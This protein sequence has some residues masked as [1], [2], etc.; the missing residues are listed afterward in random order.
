MCFITGSYNKKYIVNIFFIYYFSLLII[1][2][3]ICLLLLIIDY[4]KSTKILKFVCYLIKS[5]FNFM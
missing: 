5:L 1:V 4:L 2:V 3:F